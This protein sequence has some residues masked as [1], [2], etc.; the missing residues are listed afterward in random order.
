MQTTSELVS[1]LENIERQKKAGRFYIYLRYKGS[2]SVVNLTFSNGALTGLV[3]KGTDLKGSLDLI[4]HGAVLKILFVPTA[5]DTEGAGKTPSIGISELI[6]LVR[7][8]KD[9]SSTDSGDITITEHMAYL[10]EVATDIMINLIGESG[11]DDIK[12]IARDISPYEKPREFLDACRDM[13]AQVVG[14]GTAQTAFEELYR[15]QSK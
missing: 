4:T 5:G 3:S 15:E 11:K 2:T 13:V 8:S 12:K 7:N 1:E 10:Q 9:R 6:D 14:D